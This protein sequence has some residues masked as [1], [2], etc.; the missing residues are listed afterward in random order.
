MAICFVLGL[1]PSMQFVQCHAGEFPVISGVLV[2]KSRVTILRVMY[3][4][5]VVLRTI[6]LGNLLTQYQNCCHPEGFYQNTGWASENF[7]I[8]KG[9][10]FLLTSK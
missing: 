3:S 9:P 10:R 6:L 7:E 2:K 1:V 5:S 4:L 8:M